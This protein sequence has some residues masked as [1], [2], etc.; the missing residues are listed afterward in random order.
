MRVDTALVA[1]SV[2]KPDD[3]RRLWHN[4][5]TFDDLI[6]SMIGERYTTACGLSLVNVTREVRRTA[7]LPRIACCVVCDEVLTRRRHGL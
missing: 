3:D 7:T 2:D 4:A 1:K 5:A 6:R